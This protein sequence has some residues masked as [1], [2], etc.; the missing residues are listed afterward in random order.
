MDTQ[1]TGI[2][3]LVPIHTTT[4]LK[5][6]THTNTGTHIDTHTHTWGVFVVARSAVER[7]IFQAKIKNA[8][9]F[10]SWKQLLINHH[11][12]ISISTNLLQRRLTYKI[13]RASCRERV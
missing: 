2:H 10:G 1:D 5:T 3:R 9:L 13:G 12:N 7:A 8:P 6:D 11:S 4:H